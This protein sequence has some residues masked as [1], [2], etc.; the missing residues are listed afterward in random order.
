VSQAAS[1]PLPRR[2]FYRRRGFWIGSALAGLALLGLLLVLL[3]WL[4]QTVAGRDV[5]LAQVSARLPAGASLRWQAIEGPLA[6]PLTLRKVDFRYQDIHFSAERVHLDPDI[7]PLLGRTLRLDALELSGAVLELG[8]SSDEP[9]ELPRWPDSLPQIE[10]PLALQADRIVVDGLRLTRQQQTLI[11]IHSIRGGVELADG[12]LQARQLSA[13]TDLGDFR[14]DGHYQPRRDYRTELTASARL[15]APR[16]RTPASFGLVARGDLAQMELALA[17]RAPA[18]LQARLVL[19]GRKLPDWQFS[20]ASTALDLALLLPG[21]DGEAAATPLALDF[22]ASGKGGAAQVQG[23][24]KQGDMQFTVQPSQISVHDQVL[25]VQPLVIDA[26]NGRS[27]LRGSADFRDPANASFRFA[28]NASGLRFTPAADPATPQLQPLPVLLRQARLGLAGTMKAWAAIGRATLERDGQQAEL[29]FD[30][31][32][33]QQHARLKQVQATTPGGS[34]ALTGELAWAPRLRWELDAELAKFDPGY[35]LPGWDGNLSGAL[36]S[37]GEQLPAPAGGVSPGVTAS[38]QIAAL[39]GQLR[40]RRLAA[41]GRF[42]VHGEQGEGELEL[43]L[44]GSHLAARGKLG[45]QLDFNARLQPLQLDDLLPGAA[46]NLRGEL[47]LRGRRDAPDLIANLDGS[48]L[49]WGDYRAESLSLHGQLPWR[50]SGGELTLQGSAISAGSAIDRVRMQARGALEDLQLA[51]EA[52]NP[53]VAVAL[54]GKLRGHDARWQGELASL[55][56]TPAKGEAWTLRQPASFQLQGTNFTLADSCLGSGAGGALCVAADWPRAGLSL[57]GE[58]LP[59]ALLQ[60]W[61]PPQNG[62]PIT[63]RGEIALDGSFKPRGNA[64]EGSFNLTSKEGGLRLGERRNA[65]DVGNANRGELIHLR[66][67]QWRAVHQYRAAV[68]AGAVR[69][70]YRSPRGPDRRPCQLA[71]YPQPAAAWRRG[72]AEQLHCRISG[73]GTGGE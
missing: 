19:R 49:R 38:A 24:L 12:Q 33:D 37:T 62:R 17:G 63:L 9:F 6:G 2:R 40:Q 13:A 18:P 30:S 14:V 11:D 52:S 35:F 57:R 3:Y 42:A 34:L 51:L 43:S 7:R 39:N 41:Q 32:G 25:N 73:D 59:L 47:Q 61:L 44:G 27:Q 46:G 5:L 60:P 65:V 1:T 71:W 10:T 26:F 36:T 4:L 23:T 58:A 56:I 31:R 48:A 22:E 16:G 28:V 64:W 29:V 67:A 69:G 50:G 54:Q 53:M 70:R 72:H 8:P 68:L 45:A 20:A 66:S 55:R 15:P 21:S